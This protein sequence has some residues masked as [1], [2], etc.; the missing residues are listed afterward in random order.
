MS[1]SSHRT[2]SL[3]GPET[4]PDRPPLPAGHRPS[5]SSTSSLCAR[6]THRLFLLP[7]QVTPHLAPG[8]LRATSLT[9]TPT[10]PWVWEG[11]S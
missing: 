1:S 11:A 10:L 5:L 2:L 6:H 4:T 9:R 7:F 8:E 3:G